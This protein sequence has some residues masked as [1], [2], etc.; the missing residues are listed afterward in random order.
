M[1]FVSFR[2]VRDVLIIP[3]IAL[4]AG[5]KEIA[6]KIERFIKSSKNIT[7]NAPPRFTEVNYTYANAVQESKWHIRTLHKADGTIRKGD[8]TISR[9]VQGQD[10]ELLERSLVGSFG[11]GLKEKPTLSEV[12][13]WSV[14]MEKRFWINIY[15]MYGEIFLFE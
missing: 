10:N 14:Y 4:D 13:R 8:I 3:E 5:W 2:G 9:V 6:F 1:S 11:L 12:R 7:L 15:E